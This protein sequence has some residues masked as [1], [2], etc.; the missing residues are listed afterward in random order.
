MKGRVSFNLLQNSLDYLR[1]TAKYAQEDERRSLKYSLLH[2]AATV[3]LVVK[4]RLHQEH[5]SL[6][7]ADV[8][9]ASEDVLNSGDFRSVD[10]ETAV[11]RLG[12]IAKVGVE[13]STLRHLNEL[14]K[15]RNRVQ[16]FAIDID[17]KQMTSLLAKGCNFVLHFCHNELRSEM[18]DN[19]DVMAEIKT[20]LREFE[21]FVG[22]RLRSIVADLDS[23]AAPLNCPECWQQ[24]VKLGDGPPRCLFCN[25][26]NDAETFA[27]DITEGDVQVC[28]ECGEWT[29]ALILYNN[30]EGAWHCTFCGEITESL[31]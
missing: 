30:E 14:R 12:N 31:R 29:L 3:E 11:N 1:S 5:W 28:P 20:H 6:L 19:E 16:H 25:F 23:V 2:L 22:E 4:A 27:A 17:S 15:L 8:D 13:K 24:T 18:G 10:F 21:E 7:F 26:E 9:K